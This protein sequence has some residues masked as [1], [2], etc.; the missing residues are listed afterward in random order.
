M[1][2]NT[3]IT[4]PEDGGAQEIRERPAVA[5]PVDIYESESEYLVVADVPGAT[6]RDVKVDVDGGELTLEAGRHLEHK[7]EALSW[8]FDPVDYRRT[9]RIPKTIDTGDRKSVV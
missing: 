2:Y 9:F 1:S 3:K 8:E 5:P 6:E 4:E 7:G